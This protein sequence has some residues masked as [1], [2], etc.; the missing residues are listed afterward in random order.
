MRCMND[1]QDAD[2]RDALVWA[3]GS[4]LDR[5]HREVGTPGA[6]A[7]RGRPALLAQV[8]QHAAQVRDTLAGADGEITCTALAGYADGVI[9]I[10][11]VRGIDPFAVARAGRWQGAPWALLRLL[12][13]CQL[14][15]RGRTRR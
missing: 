4:A 3:A 14:A 9:D 6:A 11:T 1:R 7:M 10:A 15:D 5:L 2:R 8:D 13:V 12:A